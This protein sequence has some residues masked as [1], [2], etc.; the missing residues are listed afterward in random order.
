MRI[1]FTV[2]FTIICSTKFAISSE[3]IG[4]FDC[5]E[6]LSDGSLFNWDLTI[7]L[8]RNI[9]MF[10]VE[11]KIS[12]LQEKIIV[13]QRVGSDGIKRILTFDRYTGQLLHAYHGNEI[14]IYS[15]KCKKVDKKKIF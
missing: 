14:R 12:S 1:F 10:P 6:K 15:Y 7:D 3:R 11:H 2:I 8:D 13:A 4:Y 5:V 9:M